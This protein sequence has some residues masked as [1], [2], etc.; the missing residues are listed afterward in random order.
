MTPHVC[1]CPSHQ[2]SGI[3]PLESSSRSAIGEE[4]D[5]SG[6]HAGRRGNGPFRDQCRVSVTVCPTFN[7]LF[8]IPQ[9]DVWNDFKELLHGP[10]KVKYSANKINLFTNCALYFAPS[11]P[12]GEEAASSSAPAPIIASVW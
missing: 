3:G 9:I 4:G 11:V 1:I 6:M 5:A 10:K 8:L 12:P 2:V 7:V